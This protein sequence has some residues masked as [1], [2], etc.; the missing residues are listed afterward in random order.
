MTKA[1]S[2]S[3]FAVKLAVDANDHVE[4]FQLLSNC[5]WET[6]TYRKEL[7]QGNQRVQRWIHEAM[8]YQAH[9]AEY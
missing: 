2:S 3:D 5:D 6:P 8:N 9:Q 7:N 1:L 4:F